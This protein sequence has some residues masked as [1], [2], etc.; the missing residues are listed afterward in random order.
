MITEINPNLTTLRT[1]IDALDDEILALVNKRAGLAQ[2]V[3]H[4][5]AKAGDVEAL[6]IYRPEREA[7]ILLRLA[8]Q[9][10]GPLP[11]TAITRIHKAI[12][13]ACMALE[14]PL[15]VAYLGPV[16]TFSQGAVMQH[17]GGAALALPYANFDAVFKACE[18][19]EVDLAVVP[20][21]NSTEGF[22]G[23]TL[24]LAVNSPLKVCGEIEFRV[25]QNL[26]AKLADAPNTYGA[27]LSKI[28]TVFSHAQ[29]LAQCASWLNAN[30][31]NAHREAVESN[32]EAARLA[33]TTPN[34]AAIA[35]ELAAQEFALEIC[36]AG[37]ED[38][39][40]NTTRFW[41]LGRKETPPS[42]R[43]KTSLAV[44]VQHSAGS[45]HQTIEPFAKHGVSMAHIESRPLPGS[46]WEYLFLIDLEGHATDPALA[47]ALAEV[48]QRARMFKVLGAYPKAIA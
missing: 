15:R 13:G 27:D 30:L 14:A 1:Q 42:G 17:F 32:A 16:G 34:T 31:P 40:N 7:Q 5:K 18:R 6:D 38:N 47:T 8:E 41:V 19:E 43:D 23:R 44:A 21:V 29:S 9:N 37:I 28:V 22:I 48:K 36:A 3:G 11:D 33:S 12:I 39:P 4:A 35:G 26:L 24:D 45:M 2:A 20:V 25:R 46:Q 10:A